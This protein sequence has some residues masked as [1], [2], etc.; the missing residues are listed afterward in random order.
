MNSFSEPTPYQRHEWNTFMCLLWHRARVPLPSE[1]N[2]Y[3]TQTTRPRSALQLALRDVRSTECVFYEVIQGVGI[4]HAGWGQ[5]T[6][7]FEVHSWPWHCCWLWVEWVTGKQQ[8][9]TREPTRM[10]SLHHHWLF[11]RKWDRL[12]LA[13]APAFHSKLQTLSFHQFLFLQ[14]WVNVCVRRSTQTGWG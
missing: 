6:G 4:W 10:I 3:Q 12:K 8:A 5:K 11:Y 13:T 7:L 1:P 9:N 14:L 2:P